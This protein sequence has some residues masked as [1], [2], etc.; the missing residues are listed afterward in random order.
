MKLKI[1]LRNFHQLKK[2][3]A[4]SISAHWL[5]RESD[6]VLITC[7][8]NYLTIHASDNLINVKYQIP[9]DKES[10]MIIQ[11]GK[12]FVDAKL[13]TNLAEHLK[14][15]YV[16]IFKTE[17]NNFQ[18]KC[19]SFVSNLS[20]LDD[21]SFYFED[22][23]TKGYQ[24]IEVSK[25]LLK[26]TY[27]R[28]KDFVK[29]ATDSLSAKIKIAIIG[30][31]FNNINKR[32][33]VSSTDSYSVVYGVFPNENEDF[34]FTIIPSTIHKIIGL[35]S[36]EDEKLKIYLQENS[37]IVKKENLQMKCRLV[38]GS[39]PSILHWFDKEYEHK[40]VID[41]KKLIEAI[42]RSALL[43]DSFPKIIQCEVDKNKFIIENK[44]GQR[45]LSKEE[46]AI[47]NLKKS[48]IIIS[49]D[50]QKLKALLKNIEDDHVIFQFN[51]P[52]QPAVIKS[53]DDN[54]NYQEI[55]LPTRI[56]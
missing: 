39:Y 35:L 20:S 14:G 46:I 36:A 29:Q 38:E 24:E 11:E 32:L 31:N 49:F 22:F 27:Y 10:L 45:G 6:G 33:N 28:F 7:K 25:N 43:T 21:N 3:A 17:N 56:F 13:L 8:D 12:L 16:E 4:I 41:R 5:K 44:G 19:G 48:N 23:D 34:E 15:D 47:E 50:S 26:E 37:L 40:I 9:E 42:D 55:I 1:S 52:S 2:V 54:S 53:L 18:L 30:I 51:S